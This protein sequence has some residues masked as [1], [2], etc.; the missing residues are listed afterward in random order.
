LKRIALTGETLNKVIEEI[1]A[2]AG[3]FRDDDTNNL[4]VQQAVQTNSRE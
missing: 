2:F 1:H 3:L 4:A